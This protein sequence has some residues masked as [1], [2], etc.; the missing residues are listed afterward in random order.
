M[1]EN[2]VVIM[3]IKQDS[4]NQLGAQISGLITWVT[5]GNKILSFGHYAN[6][7]IHDTTIV[8]FFLD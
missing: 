4:N 5:L 2:I 3:V 8:T 6:I 7:M 1:T